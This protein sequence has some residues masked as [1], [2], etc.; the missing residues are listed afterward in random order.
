M[1]TR[2]GVINPLNYPVY[3]TELKLHEYEDKNNEENPFY[4][5]PKLGSLPDGCK[6]IINSIISGRSLELIKVEIKMWL[7]MLRKLRN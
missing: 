3:P 6:P 4:D 5:A 2:A 1:I 7:N